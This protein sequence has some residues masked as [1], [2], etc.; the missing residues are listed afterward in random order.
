MKTLNVPVAVIARFLPDGTIEPL[1]FRH[2]KREY[3]VKLVKWWKYGSAIWSDK[4]SRV[5][6]VYTEDDKI[7]ELRW[8]MESGTWE[9]IKL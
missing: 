9:L 7:A 8:L 2:M 4:P 5:Y 1:I 3:K 6:C